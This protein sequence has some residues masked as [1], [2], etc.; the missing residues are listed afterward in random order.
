MND[1]ANIIVDNYNLIVYTRYTIKGTSVHTVM[2]SQ[3][4][5]LINEPRRSYI[6]IVLS[7]IRFSQFGPMFCS[8]WPSFREAR[9]F[10]VEP[11]TC[12]RL[13]ELFRHVFR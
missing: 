8:Q 5:G 13:P 9:S 4:N 11:C 3:N 6:Y 10:R 1:R 7:G 2:G 12:V